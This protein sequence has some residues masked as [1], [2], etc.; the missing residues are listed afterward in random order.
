[1][2]NDQLTGQ[3]PEKTVVDE[4][5][6][7]FTRSLSKLRLAHMMLYF[8]YEPDDVIDELIDDLTK[9]GSLVAD[10]VIQQPLNSVTPDDTERI[11]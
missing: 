4:M 9:L 7:L 6:I 8:G 2:E 10:Q 11:D 1:M 3:N 5:D